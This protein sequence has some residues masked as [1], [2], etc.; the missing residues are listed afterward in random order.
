MLINKEVMNIRKLLFVNVLLV[1]SFNFYAQ[2]IKPDLTTAGDTNVWTL[3]NREITITDEVFLD[4]KPGNGLLWLNEINFINGEI[5]FD[6]KGKNDAGKSFVG[7]AFHGLNDSVY[8]AVYFR[9]FNFLNPDKQNHSVQYISEPAYPWY[10]LRNDSPGKYEN[11]LP[12]APDPDNWVHVTLIIDY[13][14]VK[15]FL[16]NDET[17]CLSVELISKR[18]QGFIGFWVGHY[19]QGYFKNLVIIP[20]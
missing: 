7:L 14:N 2:Q 19:S 11:S 9:P 1:I 20:Y 10:K 5:E 12:L 18:Q 4:S 17:P 8:D 15:A 6:V 3:Y 13:P 16:N